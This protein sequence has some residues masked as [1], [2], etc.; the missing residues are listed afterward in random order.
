MRERSSAGKILD[1]GLV[2]VTQV[3]TYVKKVLSC[4]LVIRVQSVLYVGCGPIKT[5][6]DKTE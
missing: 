2:V 6:E 5:N 3:Y 4:I 1:L